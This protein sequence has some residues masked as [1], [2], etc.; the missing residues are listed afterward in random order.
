V[1][2]QQRN[3]RKP[4]APLVLAGQVWRFNTE[5]RNDPREIQVVE[6]G[7]EKVRVVFFDTRTELHQTRVVAL[8]LFG[9]FRA[10]DGQSRRAR[11]RL[12]REAAERG[13]A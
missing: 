12:L 4:A 1:S 6:V 13:A 11:Y 8:K 7:E 3:R 5:A 10:S 9:P 2:E